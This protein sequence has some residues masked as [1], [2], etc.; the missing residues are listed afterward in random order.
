MNTDTELDR[1]E[2]ATPFK[3]EKA[4]GEGQTA[5]SA[6]AVGCAVLLAAMAYAGWEAL[7]V[8]EALFRIARG[9]F[10]EASR[11][12]SE[13][14][15]WHSLVTGL[16]ARCGA[17]LLAFVLVLWAAAGVASLAQTGGI[18]ALQPLRP[19]L[20]RIHPGAGLKRLLSLRTLFDALRAVLK[21]L[22]LAAIAS[23][24]FWHL[25]PRFRALGALPPA[26]FLRTAIEELSGL[27]LRLA[28]ALAAVAVLDLLFTRREFGQRMR[29]SRRELKEEVRHREG[30]PRIR[31]R[32]AELRRELL[33]RS[34][35]L[36]NTRDAQLVL[37]NPTHLAVA[38]R[39][40][41]GEMEAP[42]VVAKG[43]GQLAAAMRELAA[44][45]RIVVIEN[46]PL[47]RRLFRE[48]PLDQ[49]LP[50]DFHAEVARLFV[51]ILAARAGQGA[52]GGAA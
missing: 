27:G 45:H 52:R 51:W 40:V 13:A 5:R 26:A 29:M 4:R 3:L 38:L 44:R 48:A 36:R 30:D 8:C 33:K 42:R 19:E 39:Y 43:A 12:H 31:A 18:F 16:A 23:W 17:A 6:E 21:L 37:A 32:L 49:Y 28:F 1:S 41:R 34:R 7:A 9:A 47:A 14:A 46:P 11:L 15:A 20:K 24:T 50:A 22:L 35:A 25:L 10:V 2:A